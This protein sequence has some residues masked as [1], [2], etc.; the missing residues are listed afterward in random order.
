MVLRQSVTYDPVV[1]AGMYVWA[2]VCGPD[3]A[4]PA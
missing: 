3:L 2:N 4:N 1:E